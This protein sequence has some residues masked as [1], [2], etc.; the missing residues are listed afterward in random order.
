MG[1][2]ANGCNIAKLNKNKLNS[3]HRKLT[4]V[5]PVRVDRKVTV[6]LTISTVETR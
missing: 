3:R 4:F 1:I 5:E 6:G 2:L